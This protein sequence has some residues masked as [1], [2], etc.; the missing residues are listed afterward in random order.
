MQSLLEISSIIQKD[1]TLFLSKYTRV[2]CEPIPSPFL[3][4]GSNVVVLSFFRDVEKELNARDVI[5]ARNFVNYSKG[6]NGYY[7]ISI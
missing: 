5:V 4:R 1:I 7:V 6:N 2:F 3:R